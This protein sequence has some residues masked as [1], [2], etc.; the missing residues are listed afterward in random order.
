MIIRT[1]FA[2]SDGINIDRHFST[3][4][5]CCF[6]PLVE[7]I[8]ILGLCYTLADF[9]EKLVRPFFAS[10]VY[11]SKTGKWPNG[12]YKHYEEGLLEYY[13]EKLSL[14]NKTQVL[15]ALNYLSG[16]SNLNEGF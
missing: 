11:Y 3:D 5:K 1:A 8:E 15:E 2:T 6:A 16:N 12:Q 9:T 7:C 4:G 13:L 10:Q 14:T